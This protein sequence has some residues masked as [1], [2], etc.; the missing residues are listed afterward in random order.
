M[1]SYGLSL[2]RHGL[3]QSPNASGTDH[4]RVPIQAPENHDQCG[5]FKNFTMKT[6]EYTA[7]VS[8]VKQQPVKMFMLEGKFISLRT[9]QTPAKGPKTTCKSETV[10]HKRIRWWNSKWKGD[11]IAGC[12]AQ[13]N[14]RATHEEARTP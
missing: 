10:V 5:K 13:H 2:S 3:T 8:E 12:F 14:A 11:F 7:P 9:N 6:V 4:G 1:S